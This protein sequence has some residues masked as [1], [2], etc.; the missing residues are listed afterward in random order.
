VVSSWG[1]P[2][3]VTSDRLPYFGTL[4]GSRIHYG[5]G[6]SGHGVNAT[7][8]AGE[9]LSSLILDEKDQWTVSPFCS[10]NRM[11]FPIEPFR[12]VG[13]TMVRNAIVRCEDAEDAGLRQPLVAQAI[14]NLPR[15]LGMRVGTR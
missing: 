5:S 13:G 8:I 1:Y 9:C 2:I 14:S 4:S 10:R 7:V 3:E 11:S 12:F 15:I 6:Y